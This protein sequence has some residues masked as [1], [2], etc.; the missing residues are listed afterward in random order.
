MGMAMANTLMMAATS[1]LL[2]S[3]THAGWLH[4]RNRL[5]DEHGF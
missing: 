3:S 4:G 1:I 5:I 2:I